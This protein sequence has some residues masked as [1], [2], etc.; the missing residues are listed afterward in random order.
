MKKRK[1]YYS[2][3][4]S[5]LIATCFLWAPSVLAEEESAVT[6]IYEEI[7]EVKSLM[8]E[9][10]YFNQIQASDSQEAPLKEEVSLESQVTLTSDNLLKNPNFDQT[11]PVKPQEK[12]QLWERESAKDWQIYKDEKETKG[13][14]K[15]D[16]SNHHLTMTSDQNQNFRACVHQMVSINPEKQYLLTFDIATKDKKGQAF[17]RIIEELGKD[18]KKEQRLWLSPMASGTEVK[19]Q[20]KLYIPKLAVNQVKLELFYETGQ[21]QVVFDNISLREAGDKPSGAVKPVSH[22]LEE[23]I[24]LP[25][26]KKYLLE[27]PDYHYQ[28][29]ASSN[30]IVRVENGVLMPLSQGKTLLEVSNKEG[31]NIGSLP[32]EI[33]AEEDHQMTSLISK[34]QERIQGAE[35]YNENSAAMQALNQK[36]DASVTKNLASLVKSQE[37]KYLWKDL[38]DLDKSSNM[39]AT[40]RHLEEMAK[41]VTSPAS[42]YYDNPD[43]IRLIKERLAWLNLNVYNPQKDIEG[44]ANWWDFEIGTPR[45]IVNTLTLLYPYMTSEEITMQTKSISHFVPKPTQFRS[46]LVNPFKAIGGNLVDMGRVKVI[47]AILSHDTRGLQESIKA[48]ETLFTFQKDGSKGEGFY[49]DGSYIDHTNVAYTGAYAN[50]LIDGL[51]QLIPLIQASDLKLDQSKLTHINHWIEHSFLPLMVQGELMDMSR[52]RSISRDNAS[53]RMAALEAL[54]GILRLSDSLPEEM[55]TK[56]KSHVK[57][58]LAY[59]DKKTILESLSSYYDIKLFEDFLADDSIEASEGQSSLSLFNNMDKLAYYNADKDFAFALSMHSSKTLNFEAMNNENTRGWYTGDGMFYLYNN[60]LTH[61]SDRYWPTVN[62]LKMAGTTESESKREDVTDDYLKKLT[63]QYKATTKEKAGM[64][65]LSSSFVGAIK[66]DEKNGLAVKDFH[67]WDKTVSAKKSWAILDDQIV[68]LGTAI[69]SNNQT[70]STTIDQRK[71]NSENAYRV[72][73]NGQEVSLSDKEL[74]RDDVTSIFLLSQD[75]KSNIGYLFDQV[76]SLVF[77]KKEQSGRWSDINTGSKNKELIKQVFITISQRHSKT[78]DSYAYSLLPNIS[79][80]EFEK[81]REEKRVKVL[82]N[83][84]QFQ[85]LHDQKQDLWTVV[86]YQDG[87]ET[88]YP[89]MMLDKAG[90]YLFQKEGDHFKE[91]S[92]RNLTK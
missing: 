87:Q 27:M 2:Y 23:K 68:F 30:K 34:W 72:F 38:K 71:E 10:D 39:T 56:V 32:V 90:L 74:S 89:N 83:D 15:I 4:C 17:V 73:I 25:L 86:K 84:K 18:A 75:G 7:Q 16:A 92:H 22:S 58:I 91:L 47:E 26:S 76:S 81:A 37:E 67:N 5:S 54:R 57:A 48:L 88:L 69:N 33:L 41:Q 44:K 78:D 24:S 28:V 43:L 20:E 51:S 60:D 46:T 50:V 29:S 66:A 64:S 19:H 36:W 77:N 63:N 8:Q 80:S 3:L 42:Q 35:S 21:G 14:P 55:K 11:N 53:S 31:Q 12:N 79:Q 65:T 6:S 52:G 62:P 85:V 13:N 45:A 59:H 82:R 49:E 9:D 40:Y 61:Y 1:N 70:V